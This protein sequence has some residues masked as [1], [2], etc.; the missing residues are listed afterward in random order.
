MS[1]QGAMFLKSIVF[2][3]GLGVLYVIMGFVRRKKG[4]WCSAVCDGVFWTIASPGIFIYL[5]RLNGGDVRGYLRGAIGLG[6]AAVAV[7]AY[8]LFG[9]VEKRR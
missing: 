5:M 1:L 4:F 2:G 3:G 7:V 6:A 8:F 9:K